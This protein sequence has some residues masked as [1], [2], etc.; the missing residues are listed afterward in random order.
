MKILL[1]PI[2]SL[3]LLKYNL[4]CF[5]P[6][7]VTPTVYHGVIIQ[8]KAFHIMTNTLLHL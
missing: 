8:S 2:M 4:Q 1:K 6:T 7:I 5:V 3:S